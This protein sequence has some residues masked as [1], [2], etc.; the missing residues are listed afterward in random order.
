MRRSRDI[1]EHL[2]AI[3]GAPSIAMQETPRI[4]NTER[5]EREDPEQRPDSGRGARA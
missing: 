3:E 5:A 4:W 2:R 1:T